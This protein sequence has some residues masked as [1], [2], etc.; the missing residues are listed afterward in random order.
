MRDRMFSGE[1]INITEVRIVLSVET[2]LDMWLQGITM[3]QC[4]Y[5]LLSLSA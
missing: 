1:K 2:Y 4:S 5:A 3:R